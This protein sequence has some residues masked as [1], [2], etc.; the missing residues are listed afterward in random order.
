MSCWALLPL[1]L[2]QVG[3]AASLRP[4]PVAQP[5]LP[6]STRRALRVRHSLAEGLSLDGE[7][8]EAERSRGRLVLA[9][10]AGGLRPRRLRSGERT[11]LEW[12]VEGAARRL[13]LLVEETSTGWYGGAGEALR[14]RLKGLELI[15][16]DADCD[17]RLDLLRDGWS[18]A[19]GAP[20]HPLSPTLQLE[21]RLLHIAELAPDG[22]SIELREEGLRGAPELL[23]ALRL[24]NRLRLGDGLPALRLAPEPSVGCAE[25]A[26]YLEARGWRGG[27]GADDQEPG[28]PLASRAGR[29]AALRSEVLACGPVEAVRQLW[30][31][32][33]GRLLL[34]DPELV[35]VGLGASAGAVTVLDARA[36]ACREEG[37][38]SL[39]LDP[40]TSPA[41]GAPAVPHA[42]SG[43]IRGA[44]AGRA[45]EH[46]PAV[47]LLLGR[48]A[49]GVEHHE[50]ELHEGASSGR[51]V[52]VTPIP[53]LPSHPGVLGG[54]PLRPLRPGQEYLAI[55]RWVRDGEPHELRARFRTATG[56]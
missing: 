12:A 33:E 27:P 38:R 26:A 35:E 44:H 14:V 32:I 7:A 31:G 54:L 20:V 25:H 29:E 55:H 1:L 3:D 42:R 56:P 18:L 10:R 36:R 34:A 45:D 39:Y 19:P 5:W 23:E 48:D 53:V 24:L 46:G 13:E 52:E 49:A 17:G 50:L 22:S 2:P 16:V 41:H 21:D 8:F 4:E 43:A 30:S 47:L 28:A 6:T 11:D 40:R 9:T 15:L 37:A 51:R